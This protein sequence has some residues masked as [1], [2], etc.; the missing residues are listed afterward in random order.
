MTVKK[1]FL[2]NKCLKKL[3]EYILIFM[4]EM[5]LPSGMSSA[6]PVVLTAFRVTAP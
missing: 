6:T 3:R 1:G 5:E 2:K 4:N